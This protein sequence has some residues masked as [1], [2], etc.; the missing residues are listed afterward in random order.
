MKRAAVP[1]SPAGSPLAASTVTSNAC[2]TA[3]PCPASCAAVLPA[4]ACPAARSCAHGSRA[5]ST[6]AAVGPAE[7][8]SSPGRADDRPPAAAEPLGSPAGLSGAPRARRGTLQRCAAARS[9]EGVASRARRACAHSG[10]HYGLCCIATCGADNAQVCAL[11]SAQ[12]M[13]RPRPCLRLSTADL[14]LSCVVER[15]RQR[16]RLRALLP[17]S[18]T[19]LLTYACHAPGRVRAAPCAHGCMHLR[20]RPAARPCHLADPCG[21]SA[22][23]RCTRC[24]SRCWC[25]PRLARQRGAFEPRRD[26]TCD[27]WH[28]VSAAGSGLVRHSLITANVRRRGR[29]YT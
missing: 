25:P 14:S 13:L 15:S 20:R 19:R 5:G 2:R 11:L 28:V 8:P 21:G 22:Q 17:A 6:L 16:G 4:S 18:Q 12:R 1:A 24:C 10:A 26:Q 23:R 9:G 7:A 3:Q 29:L 27:T